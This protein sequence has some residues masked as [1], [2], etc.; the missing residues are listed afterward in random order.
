MSNQHDVYRKL[1]LLMMRSKQQMAS[2]IEKH[3]MSPIQ[4]MLLMLLDENTGKSMQE[5]T[6]T[7]ACDPSNTTGLI[8]RL[9]TNG[10]ITRTS[11]PKDRRVKVIML[12]QKGISL[13]KEVL[14]A[15]QAAEAA[16]LNRLSAEDQAA[17][18]RIINTLITRA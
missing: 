9:D 15:L 18:I 16:D 4:G 5:L 1:M 7:M 17:L 10:L 12:S 13:R 6:Q 2:V 8:D 14:D 3:N 11:D